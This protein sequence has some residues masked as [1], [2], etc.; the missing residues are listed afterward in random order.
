MVKLRK[1]V[2]LRN[3]TGAHD[4]VLGGLL[5]HLVVSFM[6]VVNYLFF[7]K[8]YLLHC[9]QYPFSRYCVVLKCDHLTAIIFTYPG[10]FGM[11][12]SVTWGFLPDLNGKAT[13]HSK[14][15]G[16]ITYP[17]LNCNGATVEV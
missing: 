2:K 4:Q 10:I 7:V 14:V 8:Q 13:T 3:L 15:W 9:H 16:E 6:H 11:V 17:F 5:P 12:V 1:M